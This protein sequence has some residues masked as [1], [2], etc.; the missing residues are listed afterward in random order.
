MPGDIIMPTE[1]LQKA[2]EH[3]HDEKLQYQIDRNAIAEH[4][5]EEC[6][7]ALR[8]LF[9]WQKSKKSNSC[10]A[11]TD[12]MAQAHIAAAYIGAYLDKYGVKKQ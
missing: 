11:F 5:L 12:V 10:E 1:Q 9:E 3:K 2:Q 4:T 6:R 8:S 7:K